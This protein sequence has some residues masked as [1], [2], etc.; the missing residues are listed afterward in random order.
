MKNDYSFKLLGLALAAGVVLAFV[1]PLDAA[2]L[3]PPNGASTKI[4]TPA[5]APAR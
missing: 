3:N 1:N 2:P 4:V 5:L